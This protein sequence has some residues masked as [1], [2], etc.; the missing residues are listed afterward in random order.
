[1]EFSKNHVQKIQE[2][3][4][5][6]ILVSR[7]EDNDIDHYFTLSS[8]GCLKEFSITDQNTCFPLDECILYRPGVTLLTTYGHPPS[9]KKK[10]NQLIR[11]SSNL[12]YNN[13]IVLGYDD[14]VVLVFEQEKRVIVNQCKLKH[15]YSSKISPVKDSR[16]QEYKDEE[17]YKK[18]FK[19]TFKKAKAKKF[20]YE[21]TFFNYDDDSKFLRS[22]DIENFPETLKD[23]I[24]DE[25]NKKYELKNY[26]NIYWLKYIFADQEQTISN[27]FR[28]VN[29]Y[30]SIQVEYIISSSRD[31]KIKIY[32]LSNGKT[33]Y[34]IDITEGYTILGVAVDQ[35]VKDPMSEKY[36]NVKNVYLLTNSKIRIHLNFYGENYSLIIN[37][38]IF[39]YCDIN[40]IV[41]F[42]NYFFLLG[43][44]GQIYVMNQK[45]E[46]F[47]TVKY[48]QP[49]GFIDIIPYNSLFL[50]ITEQLT[51]LVCQI[52]LETEKI[53]ELFYIKIGNKKISDILLR[54]NHVFLTCF[55]CN[56][57]TLDIQAEIELYENRRLLRIEQQISDNY[58]VFVEKN[59]LKKK[60]K[61]KKKK[62]GK[63]GKGKQKEKNKETNKSP[64]KSKKK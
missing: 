26:Y 54:D 51:M 41:F 7:F 34:N 53:I 5:S 57:Y 9:G 18:E 39:K 33:K 13:K 1:M 35:R 55:D 40:K 52:D 21:K 61:K 42:N 3:I 56:F 16:Y 60:K 43:K 10:D 19:E 58:N 15:S 37:T 4:S 20:I 29:V 2:H 59:R 45:F 17:N 28:Y 31:G 48:N 22:P 44:S 24:K 46:L 64:D 30:N 14:G 11:I 36:I 8:Y 27:L 47:K 49:I 25:Y 50:I 12:R 6:I 23:E 63:K 62:K 38:F 32:D